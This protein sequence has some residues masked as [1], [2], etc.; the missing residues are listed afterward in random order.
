MAFLDNSG[1]IILDA[2]LTT[3][4]R[5]RMAEGNF[6]ISK[7]ALGDDEIDYALYDK[8]NASGSAYYDLEI[9]QTPVF[10]ALTETNANITYG[11]LSLTR[12]DLLYLPVLVGNKVTS[13]SP[14]LKYNGIYYLAVN[15][16]THTKIKDT[17]A[18]SGGAGDEKY[19][20]QNLSTVG[21]KVIIESGLDTDQLTG[22]AANRTSFIVNN[23][24]LD[25]SYSMYYDNRFFNSVLTPT[26]TS[27]FK[28]D[29]SSGADEVSINLQQAAAV[30]TTVGLDNY[31]TAIAAGIPNTVY[32]PAIGS[33]TDVSA[34]AGPRGTAT[35]VNFSV[36]SG[37]T[38][39]S[40]GTR[41]AK[42]TLYGTINNAI[43]GGSVL[44]D[45]IDTTVYVQGTVSTAQLQLPV[46]I[47]RYVSG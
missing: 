7:F 11:L 10:E 44:Y 16:E 22:D 19:V 41:D 46:R 25:S 43:L 13:A 29:I 6:Q 2:V 45:F 9:L 1:D 14:L 21:R 30:S 39:T 38:A 5:Q 23:N 26:P 12:T 40:T 20:A 35:A 24:L 27:K 47:I 17:A 32:E 3:L 33:A 31:S 37:L 8:N 36:N 42:Y 34:L 18:S 4:G 28:N 15:T